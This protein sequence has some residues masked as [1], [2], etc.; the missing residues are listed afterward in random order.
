MRVSH[1]VVFDVAVDIRRSSP[2]FGKWVGVTLSADNQ[3]QLWLPEGMAHGFL[4]LS[5]TADFLYKTSHYYEASAERTIRYDD[6]CVGIKWPAI[7]VEI[8]LSAKD[9]QAPPLADAV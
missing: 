5:D 3:R 6:P 4:V 2:T 8:L 1:G 9:R 7:D